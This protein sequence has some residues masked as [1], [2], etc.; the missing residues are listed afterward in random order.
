MGLLSWIGSGIWSGLKS[1]GGVVR[2]VIFGRKRKIREVSRIAKEAPPPFYIPTT[3]K[4][5]KVRQ[6]IP[7]YQLGVVFDLVHEKTGRVQRGIEGWS[8]T[9][10]VRNYDDM[11]NEALRYAQGIAGGSNWLIQEI[12]STEWIEY[13]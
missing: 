8:R 1:I 5:T 7:M 11:F 2:E 12:V 9:R 6:P 13:A 3:V 10:S 4:H